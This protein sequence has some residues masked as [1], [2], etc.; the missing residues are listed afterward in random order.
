MCEVPHRAPTPAV[1]ILTGPLGQ[2]GFPAR[3]P[4]LG[5]V[6]GGSCAR[7]TFGCCGRRRTTR[8]R[9][10]RRSGRC[11][12]RPLTR[13][14]ARASCAR[15]RCRTAGARAHGESA[16]PYARAPWD[17]R[18]AACGW[19]RCR[20]YLE[21]PGPSTPA[22]APAV[23]RDAAA[24]VAFVTTKA[25]NV[26]A[27]VESGVLTALGALWDAVGAW[28]DRSA[29]GDV[30]LFVCS[31]LANVARHAPDLPALLASA[32]A[33]RLAA[34]LDA[35]APE[36]YAKEALRLVSCVT[37]AAGAGARAALA[38]LVP[39]IVR[40]L[41]ARME[42][43]EAVAFVWGALGNIA[44]EADLVPRVRD[45][46]ALPLAVLCLRRHAAS[47]EAVRCV[48]WALCNLTT[49]AACR[50]AVMSNGALPL[51]LLN[52]MSDAFAFTED[53]VC[54]AMVTVCNL[55]SDHLAGVLA[56]GAV[57]LLVASMWAHI[58][59][60]AV[61]VRGLSVLVDV[62]ADAAGR[63]DIVARKALPC[64]SKCMAHHASSASVQ[65]AACG[66]LVHMASDPR[67][68][69]ELTADPG[70]LRACT[71]ALVAHG[72][73][74]DCVVNAAW[75]LSN[76]IETHGTAALVSLPAVLAAGSRVLRRPDLAAA[77]PYVQLL[78]LCCACCAFDAGLGV[79]LAQEDDSWRR[80][81]VRFPGAEGLERQC[82]LL[83]AK[84]QECN[85]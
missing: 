14:T 25:D 12:R 71:A 39:R 77:G 62:A 51:V 13:A 56:A 15:A 45:A 76:A 35:R 75:A 49:D 23:V 59:S 65:T 42:D 6:E 85:P 40:V 80:L 48:L 7:R 16:R 83:E 53:V 8:E 17:A 84:V 78:R 31:A 9:A 11:T 19:P 57:P 41:E 20:R 10:P 72:G 29:G 21:P 22:A 47:A 64:V 67:H 66:V 60:E 5:P 28:S 50:A 1:Q 81:P 79:A 3:A 54:F 73:D 26:E 44:G 2:G 61:C 74:A 34:A 58:E 4:P 68:G 36:E 82:R 55:V 43:A 32:T 27:V 38:P 70:L 30:A 24:V 69:S 33:P 37:T 63:A 46:D 52:L 18:I